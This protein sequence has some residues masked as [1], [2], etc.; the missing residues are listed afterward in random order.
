MTTISA[1]PDAKRLRQE[2]PVIKKA[3]RKIAADPLKAREFLR[4]GGFVTK[5]NKLTKR[6][7]G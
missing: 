4:R 7:G 2:I 1:T 5:S 3:A 6:Y